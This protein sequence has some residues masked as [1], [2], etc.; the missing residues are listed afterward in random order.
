MYNE[1][2]LKQIPLHVP[3][4]LTFR[5]RIK[6]DM[7]KAMIHHALPAGSYELKLVGL[8]IETL[9]YWQ[10]W[11]GHY[12]IQT[13]AMD[14]NRPEAWHHRCNFVNERQAPFGS[15]KSISYYVYPLYLQSVEPFPLTD[16]PLL[17]SWTKWDVFETLLKGE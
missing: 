9:Q 17:I 15:G 16:P 14:M 7:P 12:P 1:A 6:K 3:M 11:K 2:K 5:R 10:P 8:F 13:I 4:L